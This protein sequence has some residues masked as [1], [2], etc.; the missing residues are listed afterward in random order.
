MDAGSPP[1]ALEEPEEPDLDTLIRMAEEH[2][3]LTAKVGVLAG[4]VR[5][6]RAALRLVLKATDRYSDSRRAAWWLE[7]HRAVSRSS[8]A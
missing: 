2:G 5:E 8:N 4:Q 7:A 1:I 3:P 6:L